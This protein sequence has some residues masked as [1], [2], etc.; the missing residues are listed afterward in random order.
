MFT[1]FVCVY[2]WY[3]QRLVRTTSL[4]CML[5][6]VEKSKEMFCWY[7]YTMVRVIQLYMYVHAVCNNDTLFVK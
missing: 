6:N 3:T 2:R 4:V 1:G 7:W 5:K